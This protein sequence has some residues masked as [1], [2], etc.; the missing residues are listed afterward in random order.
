MKKIS[1]MFLPFVKGFMYCFIILQIGMGFYYLVCNFG[2]V[3]LYKDTEIYL[4]MTERFVM[5][6]Y[7]GLLYPGLIRLLYSLLG[8]YY[9]IP[10]YMLQM[11]AGLF[12]VYHFVCAFTHKKLIAACLALW[13][14]TI[15]FVLQLHLSVLPHS[16][17]FTCLILMMLEVMKGTVYTR[18]LNQIEWA[19][20]FCSFT[21]LCQLTRGYLLIAVPILLW[22]ILLQLYAK[23]HKALS[24]LIMIF[25]C[26]GIV[27]CNMGVYFGT[28]QQGYYG[29]IQNNAESMYFQR[30]AGPILSG[31]YLSDMPEEVRAC[32][33]DGQMDSFGRQPYRIQTEMGPTLEARYGKERAAEIYVALGNLGMEIATK[34]NVT[35]FLQDGLRYAFPCITYRNWRDG[36]IRGATSWNYQQFIEQ[37]PVWSAR[38]FEM[39]HTL[40]LVGLCFSILYFCMV[41]WKEKRWYPRIWIPVLVFLLLY[42]LVL[43]LRGAGIYDYKWT[44]FSMAAGYAPLCIVFFAKKAK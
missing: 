25:I 40:W 8:K 16:L 44:A 17:A 24:A 21:I 12:C 18:P 35:S 39:S 1:D 10:V 6:E 7:T 9:Y 23:T 13:L 28:Q 4:E 31:K 36:E 42:G 41:V 33:T 5:D 2:T 19:G 15:P 37:A 29:R 30:T 26:T 11:G 34:D 38:Y 43:S 32:F 14:N 20:L 3:P 22:A 27:M